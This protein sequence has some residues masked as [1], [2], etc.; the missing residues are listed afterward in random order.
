MMAGHRLHVIETLGKGGFG[1]VM[2]AWLEGENGFGKEVAVKVLSAEASAEEHLCE[3]LRDEA[4]LLGLVQHRS[5]VRVDGLTRVDGRWAVVMELVRGVDVGRLLREE[6]A[7]PPTVALDILS[8]VASALHAAHEARGPDGRALRML[9]RDV[10]PANLVLTPLGDVKLLDFGNARAE[11]ASRESKTSTLTY[12]TI[13][14]MAPERFWG[15]DGP[16]ADVYSLGITAFEMLTARRFGPGG[17]DGEEHAER[18]QR[19]LAL[20]SESLGGR[21]RELVQLIGAMVDW[22]ASRRPS[23]RAVERR[24]LDLR[25]RWPGPGVRRWSER[26]VPPLLSAR[27]P[28][29]PPALPGGGSHTT[30]VSMMRPPARSE[31]EAEAAAV[32]DPGAPNRNEWADRSPAVVLGG[33]TLLDDEVDL[34]EPIWVEEP[35]A[36]DPPGAPELD[37]PTLTGLGDTTAFDI[38]EWS[39]A[40]VAAGLLAAAAAMAMFTLAGL[41]WLNAA[42]DDRVAHTDQRRA[43]VVADVEDD[44]G[45]WRPHRG[46]TAA[47]SRN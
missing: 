20:L 23:A 11:C 2:R 22:Q 5:I 41:W 39:G 46:R 47:R 40:L 15:E 33:A 3:R 36:P 38:E 17:V 34:P 21:A 44:T 9:H 28:F 32:P 42:V 14:Y 25:E 27:Q 26:V 6:S 45:I 31:A 1:V 10:K 18:V 43:V 7:V 35:P 8:D 29:T 30:F 4:R 13:A 37:A 16:A 12:G 19:R 24:L